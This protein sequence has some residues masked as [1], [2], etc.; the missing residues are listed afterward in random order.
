MYRPA[1]RNRRELLLLPARE[2]DDG[3]KICPPARRPSSLPLAD[4]QDEMQALRYL[5]GD[6]FF[7]AEAGIGA[8]LQLGEFIFACG[9]ALAEQRTKNCTKESERDAE[10][11]GIFQRENRGVLDYV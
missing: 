8:D 6:G 5:V 3:R 11:A 9:V 4:S 2:Q 7:C 10:N 1:G